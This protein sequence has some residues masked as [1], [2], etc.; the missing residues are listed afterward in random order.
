M[1]F[2]STVDLIIRDLGEARDIIDDF[3]NYPG[4][5]VIQVELAKSKC[6]SAAD[7]ISLLKN[8]QY[9]PVVKEK[10]EQVIATEEKKAKPA[11]VSQYPAEEKEKTEIQENKTPETTIFADTF[12]HLPESLNE[13]LSS[14]REDDNA[15]GILKTK[16]LINLSDAIGVND[17]FLFIREIFGGNREYY[18]QAI[19]RLNDAADITDAK[20]IIQSYTGKS[21]ETE[22]SNQLLDLV[23]RKFPSNE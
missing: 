10:K 20:A 17:R 6:K 8:T 1:D 3:R 19:S 9:P 16:P 13:Q 12:S 14:L 2:N 4:V 21:D 22:A 15:S 18:E 11:P 5:P 7:I 23:K